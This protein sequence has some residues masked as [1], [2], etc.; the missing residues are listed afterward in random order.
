MVMGDCC[1]CSSLCVGCT[2]GLL[3]A[4][5]LVVFHVCVY[6]CVCVIIVAGS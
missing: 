3:Y 4:C 1:G 5:M 6:V 2:C